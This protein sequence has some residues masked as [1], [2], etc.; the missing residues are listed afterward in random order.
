MSKKQNRKATPAELEYSLKA[1]WVATIATWVERLIDKGSRVLIVA[2]I[3][4]AAVGVS[5]NLAGKETYAIIDIGQKAIAEVL[6]K[7]ND[8]EVAGLLGY[9]VGVVGA[10]YGLKQKRLRSENI[11]RFE[12]KLRLLEERHDPG[13]TSS[14]LSKQGNTAKGDR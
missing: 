6:T 8:L 14:G 4:G 7:S 10:L 11:V 3:S 13:R 2:I 12:E 5:F 9:F 1:Q